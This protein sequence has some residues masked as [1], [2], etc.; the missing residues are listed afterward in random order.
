MGR[1]GRGSA[2][3]FLPVPG[4]ERGPEKRTG[5]GTSRE[6]DPGRPRAL[7]AARAP[8]HSPV[9]RS[10]AA[11]KPANHGPPFS[12]LSNHS[13]PF[14]PGAVPPISARSVAARPLSLAPLPRT[15]EAPLPPPPL[16]EVTE[17]CPRCRS[18]GRRCWGREGRAGASSS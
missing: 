12:A 4:H 15:P 1:S 17:L 5:G 3:V 9:G 16:S 14:N 8:P 18:L 13:R 6:R 11:P 2:G 10:L 7:P